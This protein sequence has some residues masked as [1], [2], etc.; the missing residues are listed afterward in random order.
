MNKKVKVYTCGRHVYKVFVLG[1]LTP[2]KEGYVVVS[3]SGTSVEMNEIKNIFSGVRALLD[4]RSHSKSEFF[5]EVSFGK[6]YNEILSAIGEK[7][8]V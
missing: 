2:S 5:R 6:A 4:L 1:R 7:A 8:D 3:P